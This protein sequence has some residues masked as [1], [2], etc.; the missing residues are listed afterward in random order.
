MIAIAAVVKK[1]REKK[2]KDAICRRAY[3]HRSTTLS[4]TTV[5]FHII[6]KG[7]KMLSTTTSQSERLDEMGTRST[8]G[9]MKKANELKEPIS[10]RR[11]TTREKIILL[12]AS[13]LH[14]SCFP[15]WTSPPVSLDFEQDSGQPYF[16]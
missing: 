3:S 7:P 11:L 15:P 13:K 12:H 1:R 16:M 4:A 10:K 9:S 6:I 8:K 5:I 2:R 14:G